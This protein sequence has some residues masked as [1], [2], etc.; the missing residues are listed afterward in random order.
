MRK[1]FVFPVLLQERQGKEVLDRVVSQ[2]YLAGGSS[3]GNKATAKL[4]IIGGS[5]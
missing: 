2:R 3:L 1:E 4:G 5:S